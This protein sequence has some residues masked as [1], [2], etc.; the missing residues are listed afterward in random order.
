MTRFDIGSG[1][2][3]AEDTYREQYALQQDPIEARVRR[4]L[5]ARKMELASTDVE[6]A[7]A[8]AWETVYLM[9]AQGDSI[10][11][12]GGMLYRVTLR[13]TV[14]IYRK[15]HTSAQAQVDVENLSVDADLDGLLDDQS[16]LDRFLRLLAAELSDR[17]CMAFLLVYVHG[18][19]RPEAAEILGLQ[20]KQI[21]KL[22]DRAMRRVAR[23]VAVIDARGCGDD[24][25][26]RLLRA[27]ALGAVGEEDRDYPRVER[28]LGE[29]QSCRRYVNV[30]RGLDA[31]LLPPIWLL[32]ASGAGGIL[33]A[34]R[35]IF[36]HH[37]GAW[38]ASGLGNTARRLT[39]WSRTGGIGFGNS[40][41]AGAA[42][43]GTAAV[44]AVALTVGVVTHRSTRHHDPQA[45]SAAT[46]RQAA[47]SKA[48]PELSNPT[49][50]TSTATETIVDHLKKARRARKEHRGNLKARTQKVTV[51][52][53]TSSPQISTPTRTASKP[54]AAPRPAPS[55]KA[56]PP[57]TA[58]GES[59]ASN[60][61]SASE[62][63]AEEF[64][65]ERR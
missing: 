17:Q 5:E 20:R 56:I 13:R 53:T 4:A 34:L 6:E 22:M 25:W 31:A 52:T 1:R 26:T 55:N 30:L 63:A 61:L 57:S 12:L 50:T 40:V 43:K 2:K 8:R 27:Y 32:P 18:Y 62:A 64:T 21:E 3:Q 60:R 7:Y 37:Q 39:V 28:H 41:S 35:A 42:V 23:V 24:E 16:K 45:S 14:D 49:V 38:P 19:S 58:N 15:L 48:S 11:N 46:Q 47:P 51:P 44:V 10:E 36:G 9:I 65:F 59:S 54:P 33:G 29:C